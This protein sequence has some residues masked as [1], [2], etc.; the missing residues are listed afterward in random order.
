MPKKKKEEF[1]EVV[2]DVVE[3]VIIEE[4]P[5]K[6]QYFLHTFAGARVMSLEEHGTYKGVMDS[7]EAIKKKMNNERGKLSRVLV[8]DAESG[9]IKADYKHIQK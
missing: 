5:K 4:P 9:K 1:K 6:V 7:F 3:E 8:E 2:E